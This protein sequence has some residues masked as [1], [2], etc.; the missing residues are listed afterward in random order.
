MDNLVEGQVGGHLVQAR[1]ISGGVTF[2]GS[3]E[4]ATAATRTLPSD[5]P[6]FT[7]RHTETERVVA[8]LAPPAA[9]PEA[10]GTGVVPVVV[11]DGMAGAGKTTF[12][13]HAAHRLAARYP[14]G[15][16]FLRLHGHSPGQAPVEPA[17]ALAAL[18]LD[19]GVA[20]A[21]IPAETGARERLWRDRMAGKRILLLLDD[22]A[23]S[24]QVRPLL[25]G[26]AGAAV[27]VTSRRRLAGMPAARPVTIGVPPGEEAAELFLRLAARPGS[28]REAGQSGAA[29]EGGAAGESGPAGEDGGLVELVELCGRLPLAIALVAGRFKHR[30]AWT[31]TDLIADLR[32]AR[33]R[34]APMCAEDVS[35]AG[36][37]DR[38][39]QGLP[40]DHRRFFRRLGLLPGTD[41]DAYGAAALAG[42]DPVTSGAFL[43]DLYDCHLIGEPA[44]GRFRFHDLVAVHARALAAAEDDPAGRTA[45]RD[46]LVVYYLR[47]SRDAGRFFASHTPVPAG[48]STAP[49][50]ASPPLTTWQDAAGWLAAERANL[51]AA[52]H[53]DPS[54]PALRIPQ[55][56]H[57]F[58][59]VT[60]HW[61]Q[62]RTLHRLGA[63]HAR[64]P[65][66]RAAALLDLSIV[67]YL[68]ADQRSAKTHLL[69]ALALSRAAG[70]LLGEANALYYQGMGKHLTGRVDGARRALRDA[71]GL[72]RRAGDRLGEANA[73]VRLTELA[74]STGVPVQAADVARALRVHR[75]L[76]NLTGQGDALHALGRLQHANGEPE[77][78]SGS[79]TEA[80]TR[81][82]DAGS[83]LLEANAL[84]SLG[85]LAL[86]RGRPD[87]ARTY[88]EQV[89]RVSDAE[90]APRECGR[91]LEGIGRI[92]L[93]RGRL[94]EGA[95]L[96]REAIRLYRSINCPYTERAEAALREGAFRETA[97]GGVQGG[98]R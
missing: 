44:R 22:A 38:S 66:V 31:V 64:D 8:A 97:G 21:R 91:A 84:N 18:L 28:G 55:A 89:R 16:I 52:V 75:G 60:G 58:L 79:L 20:P 82:R 41:V 70:D 73:L 63:R 35:V 51:H 77:A 67:E 72:Y 69:R 14:D 59:A 5:I 43:S 4:P 26:T 87:E 34:L 36:A 93:G 11:I 6:S 68:S 48:A 95:D 78:A 81:Y 76:G 53:Q 24:D 30:P 23:G 7:G 92:Q 12:A 42:T 49:P 29:A 50:T 10:A 54:G 85:E 39:Y 62:A 96:L 15:Q 57:G 90:F 46:R 25:P 86:A 71:L 1:D 88:F 19:A 65:R 33:D 74:V 61:D 94:D 56:V 80:L 40:P 17:D 98:A 45:A 47:T 27:L 13:V 37:F 9:Q 83:R 3:P 2:C 32:A